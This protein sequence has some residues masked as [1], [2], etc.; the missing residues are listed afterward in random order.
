MS[1][2]G[3]TIYKDFMLF[4]EWLSNMLYTS[5]APTRVCLISGN[6]TQL[7]DLVYS[8][9]GCL[10]NIFLQSS[11]TFMIA[12]PFY[13][14]YT[15][16]CES[17]TAVFYDATL[18]LSCHLFLCKRK[19]SQCIEQVP[20]GHGHSPKPV[21]VPVIDGQKKEEE[22]SCLSNSQEESGN[23]CLPTEQNHRPIITISTNVFHH[24][25]FPVTCEETTHKMQTDD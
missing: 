22:N 17:C 6:V 2:R 23:N 21:E 12:T 11:A 24:Y 8:V 20:Y 15:K 9:F 10:W 18:L 3:R 7:I 25:L 5:K 16:L 13:I 14:V 4:S 1:Y 19:K